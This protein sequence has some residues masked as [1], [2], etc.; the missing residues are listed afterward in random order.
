M[1]LA[2][3]N[4]TYINNHFIFHHFFY[5]FCFNNAVILMSH[6]GRIIIAV[7][8]K[9]T[10]SCHSRLLK[11]YQWLFGFLKSRGLSSA[12]SN[13]KDK[14]ITA[15]IQ[16]HF[17]NNIQISWS[18]LTRELTCFFCHICPKLI[19]HWKLK[20]GIQALALRERSRP[21]WLDGFSAVPSTVLMSVLSVQ[22]FALTSR[23]DF[24]SKFKQVHLKC[25]ELKT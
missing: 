23:E 18:F 1:K 25:V 20:T 6:H 4:C 14:K 21:S 16:R 17:N 5:R 15:R 19:K 12:C 2:L 7:I 11:H 10:I 24:I 8:T 13:R 9:H 22:I 3:A